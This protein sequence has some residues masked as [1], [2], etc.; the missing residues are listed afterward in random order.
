MHSVSP[1]AKGERLPV[2]KSVSS[3]HMLKAQLPTEW[4]FRCILY[5]MIDS[6]CKLNAG[7][8][9]YMFAAHSF[10]AVYSSKY[11]DSTYEESWSGLQHP[12]ST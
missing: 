7:T 8:D 12:R 10:V 2:L 6:V 3:Q 4:Q 11:L 9:E 1:A 5:P